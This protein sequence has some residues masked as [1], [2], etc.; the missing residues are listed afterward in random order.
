MDMK[1]VTTKQYK[2]PQQHNMIHYRTATMKPQSKYIKYMRYY[3]SL[4][5]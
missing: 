2:T 4:N 5:F 1:L 3:K